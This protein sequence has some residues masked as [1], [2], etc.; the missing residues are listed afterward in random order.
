MSTFKSLLLLVI[1]TCTVLLLAEG[2]LRL[3]EPAPEGAITQI[4][5][6]EAGPYTMPIPDAQGVLAGRQVSVN[7]L[8]YR[9][10]PYPPARDPSKF[11]IQVFGDSH[12][13]GI[14]APDNGTYPAVMESR[15][16]RG[17]GRYQVLNFGVGG[18]DFAS[19][20]KHIRINV[21]KYDP[22]LV[23][24]TFH[25][26]DIIETGIIINRRTAKGLGWGLQIRN[27]LISNSYLMKLAALYGAPVLRTVMGNTVGTTASETAEVKSNGPRW[28][29]FKTTVLRMQNQLPRRCAHLAVVLFPSMIDFERTPDA[30]LYALV[31]SWLQGNGIPVFNALPAFRGKKASDFWATLLDHHPNEKG[32]V[33]VGEAVADFVESNFVESTVPADPQT[34]ACRRPGYSRKTMYGPRPGPP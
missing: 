27:A 11:R 28:Q 9:G 4:V 22:D 30:E 26:G 19:I 32:Y 17:E 34:A 13:F 1:S 14:G 21:P 3:V 5:K 12:T 7:H 23:V 16:N 20:E 15:L 31:G 25:A 18:H 10:Q 29:F 6:T 33:I 8:G 2:V 24:L